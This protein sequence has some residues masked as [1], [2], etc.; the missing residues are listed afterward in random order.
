VRVNRFELKARYPRFTLSATASWEVSCAALFGA[1][2]AGKSSIVEALIGLRPEVQGPVRLAGV[3]MDG[4]APCERRLGWVPQEAALFEHLSVRD[5][6]F[7]TAA[8]EAGR[9]AATEAIEALEIEPL[10]GRSTRELSGGECSRV[11]IARAL[12]AEP[13]ML[14]LDEPLASIDRPLRSRVV[15]FLSRLA[16]EKGVPQLIVTHDP[17]E[18]LSLA[19]VVFVLERGRIVQ[20]G[21]PQEV[22]ASAASFGSLSAL[23]AENR[24]AVKVKGRG[25]GTWIVETSGG[26]RL[27]IVRVEG[28]PE[29]KEVAIRSEDVIL[30]S[31]HPEGVSAQNVFSATVQSLEPIGAQVLVSLACPAAGDETWRVKVTLAAVGSLELAPG[32]QVVL[33]IKAHS[34]HAM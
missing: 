6:I 1:S 5:N 20:A 11:A 22:F 33:L 30:M 25:S 31:S 17:I 4:L 16:R 24:F 23:G 27:S 29:P 2:G 12:A 9:R 21:D 3:S 10:L 8:S 18:V 32:R 15:P 26:Q 14:L 28:F 13:R 7:F 19:E 34:V